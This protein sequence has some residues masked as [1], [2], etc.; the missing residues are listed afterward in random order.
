MYRVANKLMEAGSGV[1][2]DLFGELITNALIATEIA[3]HYR[4]LAAVLSASSA[5]IWLS[6]NLTHLALDVDPAGTAD[7]LAAIAAYG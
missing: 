2:V 3:E 1:S 7:R 5:D 6:V 4:S